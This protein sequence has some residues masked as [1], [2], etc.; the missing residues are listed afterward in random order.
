[1]RTTAGG[2]D[3]T[4][5]GS[6]TDEMAST[7]LIV[8]LRGINVGGHAKLP[9]AQLREIGEGIGLEE[10]RTYIQSGNLVATT[11]LAPATVAERLRVAIEEATD[12]D[13]PIIVRTA[14]QWRDVIGSNPFPGA[15]SIGKTLHVAFLDG[16]APDELVGFD[17]SDFAPEEVAVRG[18]EVYLHLPD[19]IG[20]SKLAIKLNRLPGA[21]AG[22]ARNWNTVLKLAEL[23]GV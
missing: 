15:A 8:L 21:S 18:S 19:G 9:M 6:Q 13:V 4:C 2:V 3:D 1:M 11:P 22:T 16:A 5:R 10:V 12:L 7:T 23:A 20:R 17:A 14:A